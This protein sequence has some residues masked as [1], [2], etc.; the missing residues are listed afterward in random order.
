M[1]LLR[2]EDLSVSIGG[3]TILD[4]V[5]FALDAGEILALAGQ[6]GSGK[7]TTALAIAHLLPAGAKTS[8]SIRLDGEE[9]GLRSERELAAVRGRDIGL[10]F[11]E[12]MTALNPV[13]NIGEQIGE[14]LRVHRLVPKAEIP[15]AVSAL[16]G[17]V[18]LDGVSASRFPHELSGGQRQRV[19]IAIALA[20]S[21]KLIIADEPTTALDVTTQAQILALFRRLVREEKIGLILI[22]HDI[23]VVAEVA[24]RIATLD[25]GTIVE[26]GPVLEV[27]RFPQRAIT[28]GL[29]QAFAE[30]PARTASVKSSEPLLAVTNLSRR[31][32]G[33]LFGGTPHTALTDVSFALAPGESLG[34]V[35]ESGAG[36]STLLRAVLGLE[37]PDT[38]H[39]AIAGTDFLTARHGTRL[40]LRRKIQAVF[41]DPIASFDPRHTVGRIVVEPLHLTDAVFDRAQRRAKVTSVLERVGLSADAIDRYPHEFSG[42]QRQRI[43]IARALIIEPDIIAFDEALSALD[44]AARVQ[45][46]DLLNGL[47]RD[48]GISYLF[49]THD[50]SLVRA[51]TDRLIVMKSG[52]IVEAGKTEDVLSAPRDP[53]TAALVA[54]TPDLDRAL[55]RHPEMHEASGI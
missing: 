26:E 53:Y 6:S 47:S 49:V 44:I 38:G 41:Q 48:A 12:P 46:L 51:I 8:G 1:S 21:P 24:D 37:R 5:S 18:E 23:A 4:G 33:G 15:A 43:A 19:A 50:I 9:L 55:S 39:V 31:Y 29:V 40:A 17:K 30:L 54:A 11:Q 13:M 34:V 52:R 35:G 14:V 10:V 27:L 16:L 7:S 42:G 3:R 20:G 36:K 25:G 22:T 32:G 2:V 45:I 28:K